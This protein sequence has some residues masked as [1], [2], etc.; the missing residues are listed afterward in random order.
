ME[1]GPFFAKFRQNL[2]VPEVLV[3]AAAMIAGMVA[4]SVAYKRVRAWLQ[5]GVELTPG[6]ELPMRPEAQRRRA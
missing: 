3:S 5:P 2:S 4:L 6:V 1:Y